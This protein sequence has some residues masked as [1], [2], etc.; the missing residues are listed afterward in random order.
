ML[1][2][3]TAIIVSLVLLISLLLV[4]SV[5]RRLLNERKYRRLDRLRQELTETVRRVLAS[6]RTAQLPQPKPGSLSWQALESVLLDVVQDDR[7][8]PA[9]TGMF[10][11]IGF[12]A[13]HENRI[14]KRSRIARASSIDALGK[15]GSVSSVQKLVPLLGCSDSEILTVTVRSLS[16]IGSPDALNAVMDRLPVLLGNSLITRKAMEASLLNFGARAIPHLVRHCRVSA[17]DPW[18]VSC[19]LETLSHLPPDLR[20]AQSAASQ[21]SSSHAEVRSKAL[22]VLCVSGKLLPQNLV[23]LILPLLADPVWFVRIQAVKTV[24]GLRM[25][26]SVSQQLGLLLMDSHWIVRDQAAA[27]LIKSPEVALDIFIDVLKGTDNYARASV[28]EQIEKTAFSDDLM[29]N[30]VGSDRPIAQKSR[31][32]LVLMNKL[33][34]S[35]PLLEYLASG[36]DERIKRELSTFVTAG[37]A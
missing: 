22:K 10:T 23:P 32:V 18:V 24:E 9:V 17:T 37:A 21:L 20:S 12:V 30:L 15:M 19:V 34:F 27:A 28:C 35:T 7:Y 8:R 11:R 31:E 16:R 5:L 1:F 33:N 2:L 36:G 3:T 14:T 26:T 4:A 29:R 13:Y 25:Q 6:D